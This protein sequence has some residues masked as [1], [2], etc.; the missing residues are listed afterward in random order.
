MGE[1]STS[2]GPTSTTTENNNDEIGEVQQL[3]KERGELL[4]VLGVAPGSKSDGVVRLVYENV[5]TVCRHS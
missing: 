2:E 3:L 4:E 5:A 1:S